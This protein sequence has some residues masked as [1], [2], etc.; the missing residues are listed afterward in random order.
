[1]RPKED[2]FCWMGS[3]HT[4]LNTTL[5]LQKK[6]GGRKK[7]KRQGGRGGGDGDAVHERGS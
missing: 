3:C 4:G 1:V 2:P 5:A 6:R 7:E